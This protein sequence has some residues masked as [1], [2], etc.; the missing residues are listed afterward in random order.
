[1]IKPAR[2][3]MMPIVARWLIV[4]LLLML[5][6]SVM[7]IR[8]PILKQRLVMKVRL[9]FPGAIVRSVTSLH[10]LLAVVTKSSDFQILFISPRSPGPDEWIRPL[11][12]GFRRWPDGFVP[13]GPWRKPK[14][15]HPP[16]PSPCRAQPGAACFF[17]I[18]ACLFRASPGA[19]AGGRRGAQRNIRWSLPPSDEGSAKRKA[20]PPPT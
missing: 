10:R 18:H 13:P 20:A 14:R 4:P 5:T 16:V 15:K 6:V 2:S 11:R 3:T 9:Q 8:V 17:T 7:I 19:G 12:G 1:M